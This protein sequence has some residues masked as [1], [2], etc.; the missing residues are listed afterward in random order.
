MER[1]FLKIS[2]HEPPLS[3]P[4]SPA[5]GDRVT[6]LVTGTIVKRRGMQLQISSDAG[7]TVWIDADQVTAI[8]APSLSPP[9][10]S[11]AAASIPSIVVIIIPFRV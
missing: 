7:F 5:E 8:L 10:V 2:K 4:L 1:L 9:N 6:F 11:L 3:T